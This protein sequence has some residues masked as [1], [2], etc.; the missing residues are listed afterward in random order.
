MHTFMTTVVLRTGR[1]T[2]GHADAKG[3]PPSRETAE[4]SGGTGTG[5]RG[6]IVDADDGR[7]TG[8]KKEILKDRFDLGGG[9]GREH[10]KAEHEPTEIVT[11]S[12]GLEQL[13]VAGAPPSFEVDG[14]YVVW[15]GRGQDFSATKGE[16]NTSLGRTQLRQACPFEDPGD[17]LHAGYLLQVRLPQEKAV[18]LFR[19]PAMAIEELEDA[20]H[21]ISIEA[22]G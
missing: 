14:P 20:K 16:A 13:A 5:E 1:P 19:S 11:N 18:K 2:E 22:V 17:G 8:R 9:F 3:D 21:R 7:K 6:P 10:S 4:S 15:R 12:E